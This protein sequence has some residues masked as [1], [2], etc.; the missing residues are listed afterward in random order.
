MN[1]PAI[2]YNSF[3]PPTALTNNAVFFER[4]G[5]VLKRYLIRVFGNIFALGAGCFSWGRAAAAPG[6]P[7]SDDVYTL[8]KNKYKINIVVGEPWYVGWINRNLKGDEASDVLSQEK[9]DKLYALFDGAELSNPV[10]SMSQA[11]LITSSGMLASG[12]D[13]YTLI[14]SR[15]FYVGMSRSK[16]ATGV[17]YG[18]P[19]GIQHW[20]W[21]QAG[22]HTLMYTP[23]ANTFIQA[24]CCMYSGKSFAGNARSFSY[25][26]NGEAQSACPCFY[27]KADT[28]YS[29]EDCSYKRDINCSGTSYSGIERGSSYQYYPAVIHNVYFC[30]QF[31]GCADSVS[32]PTFSATS[33]T[34]IS[35]CHFVRNP[36]IGQ[37]NAYHNDIFDDSRDSDGYFTPVL[38]REMKCGS[39]FTSVYRDASCPSGAYN[40]GYLQQYSRNGCFACPKVAGTT[41]GGYTLSNTN[42]SVQ[43]GAI[44]ISAC[45]FS[46]PM[47]SDES[48]Y[49][50]LTNSAGNTLTCNGYES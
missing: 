10:T 2:P 39:S 6:V 36:L 43:A 41:V 16:G 44:G 37:D 13:I 50:E 45:K 34:G 25:S 19:E 3:E 8:G 23:T 40:N 7:W 49:F 35:G 18:D 46:Q 15:W 11:H 5:E 30:Y 1:K 21:N 32:Y 48:G 9:H 4:K 12:V 14:S 33:Y 47:S 38:T 20:F 22:D 17:R 31:D 42:V 26:G 28:M 27:M 24:G 29:G